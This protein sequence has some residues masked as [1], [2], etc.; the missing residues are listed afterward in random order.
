MYE[1]F[2]SGI[3]N[4]KR[5]SELVN[6]FVLMNLDN[7]EEKSDVQSE[8]PQENVP[9]PQIK[10]SQLVINPQ[11]EIIEIKQDEKM[12]ENENKTDEPPSTPKRKTSTSS[13]LSLRSKK[14]TA[15]QIQQELKKKKKKKKIKGRKQEEFYTDKDRAAAANMGS[16]D[17]KTS[18]KLKRKQ[19]RSKTMC[20]P[21]EA[22]P[23]NFIAL[24][25]YKLKSGNL[26]LA[27]QFY[28]K[29]FTYKIFCI[30]SL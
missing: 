30:N 27:M 9:I 12:D 18:L 28:N 21:E 5:D 23:D 14:L 25:N 6:S 1:L 16:K 24:G 4:T 3:L 13:I 15:K 22:E 26:D 29:V 7:G 20:I 8:N 10:I 17:I 2:K 19:E 11:P